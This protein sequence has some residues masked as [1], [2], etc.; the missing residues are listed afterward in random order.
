ML[1]RRDTVGQ[2][3][4][5]FGEMLDRRDT[6]GEMLD[7]RDTGKVGTGKVTLFSRQYTRTGC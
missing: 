6:A 2:E 4:C 7:W 3:G 1:D 5:R